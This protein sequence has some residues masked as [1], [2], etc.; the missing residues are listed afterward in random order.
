V[1]AARV[2][3]RI[4]SVL[5]ALA[6]LALVTIGVLM[7]FGQNLRALVSEPAPRAPSDA[8]FRRLPSF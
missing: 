8:G 2:V 6:L 4:T 7:L 3:K 5:A 1:R